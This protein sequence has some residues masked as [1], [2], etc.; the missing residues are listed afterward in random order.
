MRAAGRDVTFVDE[1]ELAVGLGDVEVLLCG[2]APRVDWSR[3][4]RLSLI[5]VLG[6]GTDSLW[7]VTGLPERVQIANAR[8]VHLPEMRDH[9]LAMILAFARELP[10]FARDQ[11]ARV[12]QPTPL[13]SVHGKNVAILGMGAVGRAIGEA[14]AGLG[15]HVRGARASEPYDLIDLLSSADYVVVTAPLTPKTR[16]LVGAKALATMK[17]SAVLVHVSRGGI[18]DESALVEALRSGT[19]RGAAL[20]VLAEEP[21][22]QSSPLWDLPNVI[23]TPHVAGLVPDYV[24]RL[25]DLALENVALVE[26][27]KPPRTPVDRSRGY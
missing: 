26:S 17:P 4:T 21:L 8:G 3:A 15:M 18:V 25:V 16:G 9:A 5:Q 2:V 1:H 14:C 22:P 23:I 7:P 6:S 24:A 11:R 10:R 20:D 12:F 13:G 27:G 19:I